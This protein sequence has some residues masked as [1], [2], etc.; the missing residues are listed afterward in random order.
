[1]N[2]RDFANKAK[3][4]ATDYNTVFM[5]GCIG[6]PVTEYMITQLQSSYP[7]WYTDEK[8]EELRL[9]IGT[10][11]FGFDSIC[12]LKSILWGWSGDATA[13]YGGAVYGSNDVPDIAADDMINVC[14]DVS[15]DFSNIEIGE[16]L[17][18]SGFAGIYIGDG[19]AVECSVAWDNKVQITQVGN[20]NSTAG[21]YNIRTWER[22][23][24]LPYVDYVQ[25]D[26]R[27]FQLGL[28][29]GLCGSGAWAREPVAYLYNGV[30]LPAL[31]EF[32][33]GCDYV[34]IFRFLQEENK[35]MAMASSTFFQYYNNGIS[36]NYTVTGVGYSSRSIDGG[37]WDE[38]R[39]HGSSTTSFS[40]PSADFELVW[41]NEVNGQGVYTGIDSNGNSTQIDGTEPVPVYK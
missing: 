18:L 29:A 33:E 25:F 38:L 19:L 11:T 2:S 4:I 37:A 3:S 9:L 8:V 26:I 24:K 30:R 27:S 36:Y 28:A 12:L 6:A 17:H 41:N 10:N 23:G 14:T 35:Y 22:H 20:I 7:D 31:P 13:T 40:V 1:M 34:A 39:A 32:P 16:M 21:Q 15:T 5:V